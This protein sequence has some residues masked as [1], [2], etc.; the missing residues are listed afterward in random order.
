M[1]I[2]VV[3]A[4]YSSGTQTAAEK[5]VETL[6]AQGH[7]TTLK[8]A[9][10]VTTEDFGNFDLVIMGSPSWKVN[11]LE[12]MPHQYFV[13]LTQR[14]LGKTYDGKKFAIFGLGHSAHYAMFCG[15]V[16]H[17]ERFVQSLK[18]TLITPSLRIDAFYFDQKN[19]EKKLRNWAQNL[20]S[21]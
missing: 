7:Q 5:V 20:A 1:N 13:E 8:N 12:G 3:Y 17:L 19:N 16:D 11:K 15:A 14:L 10:D 6:N 4:T 21:V 9:K 2:L 18:G